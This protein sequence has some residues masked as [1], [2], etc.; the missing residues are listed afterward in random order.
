MATDVFTMQEAAGRT[1]DSRVTDSALSATEIALLKGILYQLQNL[2]LATGDIQIGAVELKNDSDDTRAK[3]GS[4]VAANALRAV[5]ATDIGLPAGTN[6]IGKLA[7]NSGVDI[8]DVDVLSIAAGENHLGKVGGNATVVTVAL[9]LDTSA[10][11]SGDL[12]ADAQVVTNAM[13]ANDATGLLTSLVVVDED[14][15]GAAFDIYILDA[16]VS[17]GTENAAPSVSDADARNILARIPVSTSDYADLGGVRIAR[18]S[19]DP[20]V[21]SPASGTRNLYVAV[22]NGSG[23]PTYTATGVRLRLGFLQN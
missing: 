14:D 5:L 9:T 20:I 13:R 17:L 2:S 16:N 21:V 7:A 3:V 18:P 23:T 15:Q 19:F 4:G 22:V 1:D 6:A 8:G 12:L 11:A 10:Y